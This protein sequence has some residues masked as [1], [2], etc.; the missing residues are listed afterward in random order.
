MQVSLLERKMTLIYLLFVSLHRTRPS[1]SG[2][3]RGGRVSLAWY[4]TTYDEQYDGPMEKKSLFD[5]EEGG[6]YR[7]SQRNQSTLVFL[8]CLQA[9]L[10][11][12]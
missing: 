9:T 7:K 8:I 1:S 5:S 3:V 6:K 4:L 2:Q 12:L 11:M 10:C